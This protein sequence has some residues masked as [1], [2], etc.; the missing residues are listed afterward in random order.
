M[1]LN[2]AVCDDEA[3]FLNDIYCKV[4][5]FDSDYNIDRYTDAS[6]ILSRAERYDII[7]LDIE[8]PDSNGMEAAKKIRENGYKGYIIF[9]T[10]HSEYMSESFK[11]R[12]YRFLT[13][14]IDAEELNEALLSIA[15]EITDDKKVLVNSYNGDILVN[16]KDI[17]Y[18]SSAG[19]YTV[20]HLSDGTIDSKDSI[21][22]W[23]KRLSGQDFVKSHKSYIVSLRHIRNITD[24]DIVINNGG[25]IPVSRRN[26]QLVKDMFHEYI[27]RHAK[28]I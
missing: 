18:I 19:R 21:S 23:C 22:S 2:I 3:A 1:E 4:L 25:K 24:D 11:T 9:L 7:F 8:M 10:S 5:R 27:K 15:K 26:C 6:D 14:P 12:A 20:V 28:I 16:A 17:L 13:K